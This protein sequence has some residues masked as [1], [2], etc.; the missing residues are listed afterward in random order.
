MVHASR[1]FG[2]IEKNGG[3]VCHV[4]LWKICALQV[5]ECDAREC[6]VMTWNGMKWSG[7]EGGM[8]VYLGVLWKKTDAP[9][10]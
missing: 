3:C 4:V 9:N 8:E 2:C 6:K 7:M 10:H 1:D 5:D